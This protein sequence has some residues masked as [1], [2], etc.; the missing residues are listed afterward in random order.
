MT[1]TTSR[2]GFLKGSAAAGAT[3]VIGFNLAGQLTVQAGETVVKS[4]NPFIKIRSDNTIIAVIKHFEMGQGTT[5]GLTTIL[6]EELDADWDSMVPE[7]APADRKRYA[8]L[9]WGGAQGTG[10]SSAIA[11]SFMQYRQAGAVARDMLVRAAA[12]TWQVP[13][14]DITTLKGVL[15]HAGSG[16]SATYGQMVGAAA[17]L[18]P[19]EDVPLKKPEDFT[20]IGKDYLPRKDSNAKTDGS[21][22]FAMDVKIPNMV[23]VVVARPPR[24]GGKVKSFD[25]SKARAVRGVVDVQ[26]IPRGIAVYA[27]NTWAALKG[28]DALILTWDFSEA[29]NRSTDEMLTQYRDAMKKTGNIALDK[30]DA[31]AASDSAEQKTSLEFVFPFLAHA[32]MEPQNC[33]I[34]YVEGKSAELWDGCQSPSMT[35]DVV[36][37]ILDLKIDDV[38]VNTVYAGGSFGRRVTGDAD[39]GGEAAMAAKA[40]KG[41]Y[42]VKLVWTREDDLKGGFYRPMHV[43]KL[44]LA[45]NQDKVP[46]LW[47]HSVTGIPFFPIPADK[48]DGSAVEGLQNLP[49][50]IAN[51]KVDQHNIDSKVTTLWWRSVGHSHTA[52]SKEVGIDVMAE[53]AGADPL[54][55]RL[56]LLK[57][58][59]REAAVLKLAAEKAGWGDKMA[60][61]KGRGIAVHES[62]NSFV[63]QVVDVSKDKDGA[64]KVDRVVCVIDCGIVINPDVV[65]AQMEGGI[66]Y[67]LGAVMRNK[68]S[69]DNGE[70]EQNNFPDY[71]PLRMS[72]MPVVEVHIIPSGEKPT[73]VGEPGLPPLAPALSNAIFQVT[74]KRITALPMTDS[75]IDFA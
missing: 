55:F 20:L 40:I 5:T 14:A 47:R 65:R 36:A 34:R 42:A 67:G 32:P 44:D 43:E 73:G 22:I 6:A 58:H 18:T 30:G 35:Q 7:F 63:A 29:E 61:G 16:K 38:K 15:S 41:K 12:A 10:G 69:F 13:A 57:D 37:K 24:F 48:L 26:K 64:I 71:L 56:K 46:T 45:L 74:G 17:K 23:Y 8:N 4:F 1:S 9:F 70:V 49:Y 59:P 21:A 75:G 27:K 50:D 3:L 66:G 25:D 2:R 33:V 52:Y 68:I 60:P 54:D 31:A 39:Y 51:I 28:R 19:A 72:D 53:M 11:N 62:F